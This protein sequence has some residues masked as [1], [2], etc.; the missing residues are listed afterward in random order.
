MTGMNWERWARATGIG[1]VVMFIV[2]FVVYG[3]PPKVNDSAREIVSF[4]DGD[5]GRVLTGLILFGIAFILLL[6]FI[7]VI[8]SILREAGKGGWGAMATAAGATFVAV[9]AIT[10]AI[11]GALALNIAAAGDEGILTGLNTLLS[12]GDVISAY[13]LAALIFAATIGLSRAG[14]TASWYGWIGFLA[15]ALV[16]LHGTNYATSG[17]WSPTGGYVFVTVI[18][19]L[20]WTLITSV[21][22]YIHAP[23]TAAAP[24]RAAV[25]TS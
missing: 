25:P 6:A 15:A 19:G 20:G 5:R 10:G 4:F 8:A 14:I 9:Q 17:F 3:E 13:P 12:T 18:A 7:G 22:L 16:L 23:A 21:L 11:A 24:Q 1:F 2:A